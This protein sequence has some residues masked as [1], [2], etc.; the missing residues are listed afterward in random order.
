MKQSLRKKGLVGEKNAKLLNC[1]EISN[2]Q[3]EQEE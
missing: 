1:C 3:L 2:P